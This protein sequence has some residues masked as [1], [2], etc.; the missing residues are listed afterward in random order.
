MLSGSQRDLLELLH[1]AAVGANRYQTV[2]LTGPAG[3]GKRTLAHS[4]ACNLGLDFTPIMAG[5]SVESLSEMLFGTVADAE[6]ASGGGVA[7][8]LL[9]QESATVLFL[10]GLQDLPRDFAQKMR[11]VVSE[12]RYTDALGARQHV[13]EDIMIIGSRRIVASSEIPL[14]HWLW[15]AFARRIDVPVPSAPSCLMTIAGSMLTSLVGRSTL[16]DDG[17]LPEVLSSVAGAGDHLHLLRRLL[18]VACSYDPNRPVGPASILAAVPGDTRWL[19]NQVHFRG[20][21]LSEERLKSWLD[22]FPSAL[23]P[24]ASQLFR[25]VAERYF[26]GLQEYHRALATLID[27]SGIPEFGRVSFCEWQGQGKSGPRVAHDLKNQ[28][29]WLCPEDLD[30]RAT[31]EVWP[32]FNGKPPEWFVIT[33]DIVGS[34][35]SL[36]ACT[37]EEDAP[38]KRLLRRFPDAKLRILVVVGF[39]AA[40]QDVLTD[41]SA[42]RDRVDIAA[43]R[44]LGDRDRCFTETSEIITDPRLRDELQAFCLHGGRLNI[45]KKIRLGYQELAALVVF[46][47][48]VPNISL[49]LLWYDS[50]SWQS[51]FPASGLRTD[52]PHVSAPAAKTGGVKRSGIDGDSIS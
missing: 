52:P 31:D 23:Q 51:L 36:R 10:S 47:N 14:D 7:P 21:E 42:F 8:G 18:G 19:L 17:D 45:N 50:N 9:G 1:N 39:D 48:T 44:R 13:A 5:D 32:T 38:V 43:Y 16:S 28:G 41:L 4:L 46:H 6:R 49:P 2:L 27:T 25:S 15:T 24:L 37:K 26:I 11:T 35:G 22:Q 33:D 29:N 12:R 20:Q 40:L 30:L 3:A 34:G